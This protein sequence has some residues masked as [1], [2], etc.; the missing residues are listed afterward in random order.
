[1]NPVSS[2]EYIVN[3]MEYLK[4]EV[5][6]ENKEKNVLGNLGVCVLSLTG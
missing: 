6:I 1:M 2:R 3:S 4:K 5:L